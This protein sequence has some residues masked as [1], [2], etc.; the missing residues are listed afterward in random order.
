MKISKQ[1]LFVVAIGSL[2][3]QSCA[4]VVTKY[5][6][7]NT[8]QS[9]K[10]QKHTVGG[11]ITEKAI[12]PG[13]EKAFTYDPGR[14]SQFIILT[15]KGKL[16]TLEETNP[17]DSKSEFSKNETVIIGVSYENNNK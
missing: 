6:V 4:T 11:S 16:V 10:V 15:P 13:K 9:L 17:D 7:N 14:L 12:S 2:Y 8:L 3:M 1:L 5:F